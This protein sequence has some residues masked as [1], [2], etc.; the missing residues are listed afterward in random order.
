MNII[1]LVV[2]LSTFTSGD[3]FAQICPLCSKERL[4]T[5]LNRDPLYK[6]YDVKRHSDMPNE[7]IYWVENKEWIIVFH[8]NRITNEVNQE[9]HH[10]KT[11]NSHNKFYNSFKSDPFQ[12]KENTEYGIMYIWKL[13][14]FE[15]TAFYVET[16]E[17]GFCQISYYIEKN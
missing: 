17:F 6:D 14:N 9:M 2:F 16:N 1:K 12:F 15:I 7:D 10:A 5:L 13:K 8:L 11:Y 4:E 3:L